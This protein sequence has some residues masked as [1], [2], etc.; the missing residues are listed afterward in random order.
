MNRLPGRLILALAVAA[1]LTACATDQYY[2]TP[3]KEAPPPAGPVLR[4][5]VTP[6]YPPII[7]KQGD[8]G[9]TTRFKVNHAMGYDHSGQYMAVGP[10]EYAS[11]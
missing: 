5:G 11:K 2:A 8:L 3:S 4:V 9:A 6:N 10:F 7:F 1:V